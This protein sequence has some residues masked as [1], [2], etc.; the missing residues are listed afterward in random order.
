M[1]KYNA[2]LRA[3]LVLGF[4]FSSIASLAAFL[5]SYEEYSR[6]Y[7]DKRKALRLSLKTAVFAFMVFLILA[8]II[9][10]FIDRALAV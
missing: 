9:G 3:A 4:S 6:H 10:F 7:K 5:I 8:I 2:M 1:I